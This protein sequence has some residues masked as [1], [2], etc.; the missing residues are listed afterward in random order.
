MRYKVSFEVVLDDN[1][2]STPE[3][4]IDSICQNLE[5]GECVEN[6]VLETLD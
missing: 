5:P 4:I 6:F 3:W 2:P 1:D